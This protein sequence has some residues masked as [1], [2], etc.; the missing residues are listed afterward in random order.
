MALLAR[1]PRPPATDARH[2]RVHLPEPDY[3]RPLLELTPAQRR[4]ILDQLVVLYGR[5]KA[6]A[7]FPELSRLM[8][9]YHAHR[10]PELLA[11]AGAFDPRDRFTER[12]VILITYGDLITAPGRS[13]LRTLDDFLGTFMKGS[14]NTVHLLP[15]FPYSSDR[16]FAIIDYEDVDPRLG[17]W[18]QVEHLTQR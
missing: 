1:P 11:D 16:G 18:Q 5:E 10:T 7:A 8:K 2:L 12:D 13:P 14:I 3:N 9:V 6:E 17:T 4:R 15:F